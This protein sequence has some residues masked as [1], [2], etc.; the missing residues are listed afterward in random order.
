MAREYAKLLTRIWADND[1][2]ALSGQAQRL[3]FQL[4]S[5]PD[6]S[7]AGVV[8]LA[9]KRWSLQVGDQGEHDIE[10]TLAELEQRR[11]VVV[12]RGT[13]EVLIRSFIRSDGGWKSPTTMK[14]IDS[15]V[16]A[17]LS[18]G[19]KAVM[20][21]E[22]SRLDMSKLSST[23]SP[24]TG[25]ST[26]EVVE[27][28]AWGIQN[29]FEALSHTPTDTPSDTPSHGHNGIPHTTEPEP[30]P[31]HEPAPETLKRGSRRTYPPD[32]E[33]FWSVYPKNA[34]KPAAFKAWE[35]AA[36]REDTNV[37]AEGA[38]RYRDDPNRDDAFTKNAATW[39][40]ADAWDN[41]PL[42]ARTERP[43][44]RTFDQIRHQNN[45][46][47]WEQVKREE[48]GSAPWPPRALGA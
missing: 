23:V 27:G 43:E 20:R 9:E 33:D 26:R 37:I 25:K 46:D 28:I 18:D 3:Y 35:R 1:F 13:Q 5:Q 2:K 48:E 6:M 14:S 21:D 32:F 8:T 39:L 12:D 45:L 47:L 10:S 29:D 4:I 11:F 41:D 22:V 30:E 38:L 36:D 15:S 17:T 16:R 24:K 40:N 44:P 7:M 19:L 34:D 42:P 31:A